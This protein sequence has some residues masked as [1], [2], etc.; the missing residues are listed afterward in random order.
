MRVLDP[1]VR[2]HFQELK[3]GRF[4]TLPR[5][6]STAPARGKGRRVAH[7]HYEP[8]LYRLGLRV[9]SAWH[10]RSRDHEPHDS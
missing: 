6:E 7:L 1:L 9:F 2:R 3:S 8:R 10:H 4:T 5:P